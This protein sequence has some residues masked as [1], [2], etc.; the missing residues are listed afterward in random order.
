MSDIA[1]EQ[2]IIGLHPKEGL[3]GELRIAVHDVEQI[4]GQQNYLLLKK[5]ETIIT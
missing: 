2:K 5:I 1:L 3:Y 4:I